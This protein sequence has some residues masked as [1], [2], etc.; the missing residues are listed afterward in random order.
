M[1]KLWNLFSKREV[2]EGR[3][4]S[5]S[6]LRPT[7][8]IGNRRHTCFWEPIYNPGFE[9]D[10]SAWDWDLERDSGPSSRF[11]YGPALQGC[12]VAGDA[13]TIK[14]VTFKICD[15]Q[16]HFRHEAI[17]I[18]ENCTFI[19]CDFAYSK[20]Q[21]AHFKKCTFLECSLSLSSF[22]SCE[23][24]GCT[25]S[26]IGMASKTELERTVISNP[27]SLIQNMVSRSNP[28]TPSPKHALNQWYRL[29]GT[30]AHVLRNIMISH[31][32]AG[33]EHNFYETVKLHELQRA[34][35]RIAKDI[36]DIIFEKTK[37][38]IIAA[39][40][41]FLHLIDYLVLRA[42]GLINNWGE[43][44]SRPLI[45]LALCFFSFSFIYKYMDLGSVVNQPFQKSFDITFLVGYTDQTN[46]ISDKLRLVQDFHT[47]CSIA[48][49]S[50]FFATIVSKLSRS[51]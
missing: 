10:P 47:A 14:N 25:W 5:R 17:L 26:E 29:Q 19:R 33:D 51:R 35:A 41:I 28:N 2:V 24:G 36:F 18:F 27:R 40:K 11:I 32:S 22:S 16:G 42:F 48:I 21:Y 1:W 34:T 12:V 45:C 30:R 13:L 15:F 6:A 49:Y 37:L 38:K 44:V 4:A 7:G 43:S 39:F 46:S 8:H 20:W 9:L 23:F 31:Q 3:T 50:I